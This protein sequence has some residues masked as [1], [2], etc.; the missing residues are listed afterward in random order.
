[1]SEKRLK[2]QSLGRIREPRKKKKNTPPKKGAKMEQSAGG[3]ATEGRADRGTARPQQSEQPDKNKKC[4]RPEQGSSFLY[5]YT[6]THKNATK[7][8]TLDVASVKTGTK[9]HK[10]ANAGRG[11][12]VAGTTADP[13]AG[14][15]APFPGSGGAEPP[16]PFRPIATAA[17]FLEPPPS[18]LSK[19]RLSTPINPP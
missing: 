13:Q 5:I 10:K 16:P 17:L 11:S 12:L 4:V 15:G 1:M 18:V 9:L 19:T 14:L 8:P 7:P 6:H 2:K 3:R